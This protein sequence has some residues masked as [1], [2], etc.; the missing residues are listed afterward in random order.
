MDLL[1]YGAG[2]STGLALSLKKAH[3]R[4]LWMTRNPWFCVSMRLKLGLKVSERNKLR[5][6]F[7]QAMHSTGTIV[8]WRMGIQVPPFS[9]RSSHFQS[10]M[11]S[12][13]SIIRRVARLSWSLKSLSLL[14]FTCP[15][16]DRVCDVWTIGS[17]SGTLTSVITFA[18]F[19]QLYLSL[20]SLQVTL[21]PSMEKLTYMIFEEKTI[22]QDWRSRS[23]NRSQR[24][25][26]EALL[27]LLG[28]FT[29][30]QFS[31]LVGRMHL[32]IGK[33]IVAFALT[34]CS[35]VMITIQ[36]MESNLLMP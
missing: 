11:I 16:L 2:M 18:L 13:E 21:M 22:R 34:I 3:S 32:I 35:S 33:T 15:M 29:Q 14:L 6:K 5:Q 1:N 9:R 31:F 19:A 7:C 23:G 36:S 17:M 4:P 26:S 25:S 20:W 12:A 10:N 30:I 24:Y 28:I 8:N 27:T